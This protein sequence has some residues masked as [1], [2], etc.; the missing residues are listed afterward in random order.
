MPTN[1]LPR[2]TALDELHISVENLEKLRISHPDGIACA[3][4]TWRPSAGTLAKAALAIG[5]MAGPVE[6]LRLSLAWSAAIFALGFGALFV[7]IVLFYADEGGPSSVLPKRP[8]G[9]ALDSVVILTL[10]GSMAWCGGWGFVGTGLLFLGEG[11][12]SVALT[13]SRQAAINAIIRADE[14]KKGG[15]DA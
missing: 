8:F 3:N 14:I 15:Q 10:A 5:T 9:S 4:L 2:L 12:G 6:F 1:T 11:M 7:W 13:F